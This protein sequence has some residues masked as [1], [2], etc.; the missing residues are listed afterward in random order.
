MVTKKV[1]KFEFDFVDYNHKIAENHWKKCKKCKEFSFYCIVCGKHGVLD[2]FCYYCGD[3]V[4]DDCCPIK[5]SSHEHKVMGA[6][7]EC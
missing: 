1:R 7:L 2:E 5:F 3:V 6:E 4:C